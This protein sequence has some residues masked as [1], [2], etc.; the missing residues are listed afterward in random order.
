MPARLFLAAVITFAAVAI[1]FAVRKPDLVPV[2]TSAESEGTQEDINLKDEMI[3]EPLV[4]IWDPGPMIAPERVAPDPDFGEPDQ[5][6]L[7]ESPARDILDDR[8]LAEPGCTIELAPGCSSPG[9]WQRQAESSQLP[10]EVLRGCFIEWPEGRS[11]PIKID[12]TFDIDPDG[13]PQNIDVLSDAQH[14]LND[15]LKARFEDARFPPRTELGKPVWV[16]G[17]NYPI[18]FVR[19]EN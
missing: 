19:D 12:V 10:H 2:P 15:C 1:G 3:G 13:K 11:E 18:I 17:V 8:S 7:S 6:A 5:P 14:S 16:Y 9:A 4:I